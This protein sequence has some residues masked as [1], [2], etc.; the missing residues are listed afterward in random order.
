MAKLSVA[1]P[2]GVVRGATPFEAPG[3]WWDTSLVRWR[4]GQLEPIGGWAKINATPLSG[5]AR[6]LY[7][8]R[9]NADRP[10]IAAGTETTLYIDSGEGFVDRSPADLKSFSAGEFSSGGYGTGAYNAEDYGDTR[11]ALEDG[12]VF[13]RSPAWSF[14]NF[15]ENLIAVSSADGRLLQWVPKTPVGSAAEVGFA[16]IASIQRAS[17]VVTVTT[18]TKHGFLAGRSVTIGDVSTLSFNGDF[19]VASVVSDTQFTYAQT[20][21]NDGP[22]TN[23]GSAR[24]TT[25]PR[26]NRAVFVTPERHVVLLGAN[27]IA[28]RVGWCS[29]EDLTDWNYTSATNTAGYL[30]LDSASFLITGRNVQQGSLIWSDRDLYLMSFIG[31]PFIYS[32]NRIGETSLYNPNMVATIAGRA[33]WLGRGGF[34]SYD[35]NLRF[36]N[37]PVVDYVLSDI[38]PTFGPYRAHASANGTYPEA[39]FFYPSTGNSECNRYVVYNYFEDWWA[40]GELSRTAMAPSGA[41]PYPLA[42]DADG[43]LYDHERGWLD[44]NNS[45]VGQVY[46]ESAVLRIDN[47]SRNVVMTQAIPANGRGYDSMTVRFYAKQTG[48]G[49][50]RSFGPYNARPDG[51]MDIRVNGRDVRMRVE[52]RADGDWALGTVRLETSS[53]GNR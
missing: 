22:I 39:W 34:Y 42:S 29:R 15:G 3:R 14:T 43:Y 50:E 35:G 10:L 6:A 47:D 13:I 36:L 19:T 51:Y 16:Q 9:T 20:G 52:N 46:A 41:R 48:E 8:W 23:S 37:C 49:S 33:I 40:I 31:S 7:S 24:L 12:A 17:N 4:S 44:G 45:R 32:I 53:G 28:R 27:G 26:D 18:A 1:I 38:D 21:I 2:P 5:P 25:V 30:E 11:V